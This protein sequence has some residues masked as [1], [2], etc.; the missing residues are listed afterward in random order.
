[1]CIAKCEIGEC[2]VGTYSLALFLSSFLLSFQLPLSNLFARLLF[3]W[4]RTIAINLLYFRI[5]L[6]TSTMNKKSNHSQ[7][8]K[9]EMNEN[10][11]ELLNGMSALPSNVYTL[12][13]QRKYHKLKLYWK[14]LDVA[15]TIIATRIRSVWKIE[16]ERRAKATASTTIKNAPK[17]MA[18]VWQKYS[19]AAQ[20]MW[21]TTQIG[22]V[23]LFIYNFKW[24][25]WWWLC[26]KSK[27]EKNGRSTHK[28]TTKLD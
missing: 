14:S 20:I 5:N 2:H 9:I 7:W 12:N 23:F 28:R 24:V 17:R 15:T 27:K 6:Y 19:T 3:F 8:R 1:M 16:M 25:D 22:T 13:T 10:C 21:R 26:I 11:Y 4:F 18:I